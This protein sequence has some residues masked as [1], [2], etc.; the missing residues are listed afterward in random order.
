[1]PNN[2]FFVC[3]CVCVCVVWTQETASMSSLV[4]FLCG[5]RDGGR[6]DGVFVANKGNDV[7]LSYARNQTRPL[8]NGEHSHSQGEHVYG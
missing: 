3:V 8:C 4:L 2:V 5:E 1:M 7:S 6:S